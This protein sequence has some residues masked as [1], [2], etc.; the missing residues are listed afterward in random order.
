LAVVSLGVATGL[1]AE[2]V[3][4]DAANALRR[5]VIAAEEASFPRGATVER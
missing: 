4:R 5:R 2:G 1:D 3:L